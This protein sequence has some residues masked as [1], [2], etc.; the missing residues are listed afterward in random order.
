MKI[1]KAY[2]NTERS[3]ARFAEMFPEP[4][5]ILVVGTQDGYEIHC[6]KKLGHEVHGTEIDKTYAE[7]CQ[8]RDYNVICDNFE[9]TNITEKYDVIY[10]SHVI[11]H[12][13]HPLKFMESAYK[14]L[15]NDGILFIYFPLED[16]KVDKKHHGRMKHR[17]FWKDI[18]TFREQIAEKSKFV[19]LGLAVVRTWREHIEA[20]YVGRKLECTTTSKK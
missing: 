4:K 5:K 18:K 10:S 15:K 14:V 3:I 7:F 6:L 12:C 19:E 8:S 1:K 2:S 9:E 17:S 16:K 13:E 20:L 11:E